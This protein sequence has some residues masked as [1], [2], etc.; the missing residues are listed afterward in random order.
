V[1]RHDLRGQSHDPEREQRKV[2]DGGGHPAK[3]T[4][5]SRATKTRAASEAQGEIPGVDDVAVYERSFRQAGLPLLIEDYSAREDVF[6]RA[7][8]LL[9][10]VLVVE[11]LG[12]IDLK[13]SAR[14]APARER[15]ART[16]RSSSTR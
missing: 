5:G 1:Q 11:V 8:P 2:A 15:R 10:V 3:F 9:T 13:C 16:A 12:A 14:P 6:T 4:S 7:V